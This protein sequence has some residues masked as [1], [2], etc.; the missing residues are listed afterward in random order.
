VSRARKHRLRRGFNRWQGRPRAGRGLRGPSSLPGGILAWMQM[1]VNMAAPPLGSLA[2][3][4]EAVMARRPMLGPVVGM[5]G[6][7]AWASVTASEPQ[8]EYLAISSE[9]LRAAGPGFEVRVP[10]MELDG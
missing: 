5:G 10:G 1:T 4:L 3:A 8:P 7:V 2:E 6:P 9:E